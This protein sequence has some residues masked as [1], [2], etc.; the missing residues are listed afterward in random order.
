[1]EEGLN[2]KIEKELLKG[3]EEV[4]FE[5]VAGEENSPL[6]EPV[7]ENSI[8]FDQKQTNV[9]RLSFQNQNEQEKERESEASVSKPKENIGSTKAPEM[10]KEEEQD[11]YFKSE[12]KDAPEQEIGSGGRKD[13][14]GA[15]EE[16]ELPDEHAQ[17]AAESFLG[18]ADNLIE[19]GGGFFI[20]IRKHKDFYE[21]EEIIQIIDQ[22]NEKNV[23][24]IKLDEQ[25]KMLLRPLLVMVL[26]RK[27]KRLTPEQQLIGVAISI[28]VKKA[29]IVMEV[30]AENEI[31][32]ER[33]LEIIKS[34]LS[35]E[36]NNTKTTEENAAEK[37]ESPAAPQTEKNNTSGVVSD[38][39]VVE[40]IKA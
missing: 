5:Q 19:V 12:E 4:A 1:M 17:M 15:A 20:K 30:R 7:E 37:K 21:F 34:Q 8:G 2:E 35:A 14:A 23:N 25:D 26:K 38:A 36:M 33:M 18:I 13:N 28:I 32:V 3:N 11:D 16:F 6:N 10:K 27:A 40:E 29:K 22:Q 24:R 39:Q 9:Q 31:L